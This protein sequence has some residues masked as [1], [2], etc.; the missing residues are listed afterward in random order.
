MASQLTVEER[1]KIVRIYS[2]QGGCATATRRILYQEGVEAGKWQ[3][4]GVD[5]AAIPSR[6]TIEYINKT[7]DET[8][9][10]SKR[11]LKSTGR[12]RTVTTAD[13]LR[14]VR[15]EVLRSPDVSKSHRRLSATLKLSPSSVYTI[16]KELKLKPYIPRRTQQ[17]N[18]D[19]PDRRLEFC[20]VWNGMVSEDPSFPDRV[21]WSDEAK[22]HLN[23]NVNRH[24]CV[25]W[26][27]G[28]LE[29]THGKTAISIGINV[30]CG[31][32]SGGLLGP[33]FIEENVNGE[34]YLQILKKTVVP[35]FS[36]QFEDF[37]F[38]QDGAPAHY[39]NDV[40]NYLNDKLNGSWIG[41]RG[42]IEW[43]PRSPDLSPLDFFFWGVMKDRVY[44]SK[45]TNIADLKKA[46]IKEAKVIAKDGELLKKVCRSVTAR[47]QE[48]VDAD[49]GNFEQLR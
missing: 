4:V 20:E 42:A 25:F 34:N 7:F 6:Q 11:M 12:E 33:I 37:V 46:I 13:N 23:G 17:L 41:R 49:G 24:N 35:F 19:D 22:F 38:Q 16:L 30:W 14:R 28:P 39:S 26:R 3:E 43:P 47:I 2:V 29:D 9:C 5:R 10:V 44:A 27:E 45:F 31:L 8:G 1:V 18:A 32:Y 40:R 36:K 48:C 15:E 21:M